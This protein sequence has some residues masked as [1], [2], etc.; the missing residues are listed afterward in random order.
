MQYSAFTSILRVI[1]ETSGKI[2]LRRI[3]DLLSAVLVESSV[4]HNSPSSFTSLTSS[5]ESFKSESFDDKLAFLDNCICRVAKRP[6]QYLDMA[7]SLSEDASGVSPLVAAM[8]EQWPFLLKNGETK[9][10][11]GVAAW[12]AKFLGKLRQAGENARGLQ[13]ARDQMLEMTEDK[14]VRSPLKKAFR[15]VEAADNGAG[16]GVRS[17]VQSGLGEK[18]SMVS[19]DEPRNVSLIETFGPLPTESET[20][21][22][23]HRWEK[24]EIDVAIEE[25][26]ITKLILCLSSEYEEVRRQAFISITRFMTK[27]KVS[28][29]NHK[30]HFCEDIVI[31]C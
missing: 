21:H 8:V 18:T 1:V 14:K 17:D 5:L 25:G 20:R 13:R 15:D 26:H 31:Q 7:A 24:E 22:E 23:L 12:I 27:L 10:T 4:L 16:H 19:G 30:N 6:V 3:Y 9:S 2:P 28:S 11:A 29:L